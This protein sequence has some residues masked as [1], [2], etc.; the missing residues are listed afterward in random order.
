MVWNLQLSRLSWVLASFLLS[1][2]VL[3]VT[4]QSLHVGAPAPDFQAAD[5]NGKTDSLDQYR[6]KYVV[7]E[8]HN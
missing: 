2:T 1:A 4:A 5:S 8:W 7:L 3:P 6:G